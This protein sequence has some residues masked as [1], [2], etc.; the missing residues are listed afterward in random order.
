MTENSEKISK[1]I[2]LEVDL[3]EVNSRL[4]IF[5]A[6][7]VPELTRTRVQQLIKSEETVLVNGKFSKNSY[8]LKY[9]DEVCIKIPEAKPLEMEAENIP[10]DVL[11]EEENMLII[12][13]PAGM[14]THP[15]SIEREHTLVNALLFH[16]KGNLSGINGIMRPGILHRLDRDTSGLLMIAKND[17]AHQFLAEQIRTKTAVRQYLAIVNGVIEQDEGTIDA[18]ID[19]HPTQRHKMGVVED[20]KKS[21]THW[22]VLERFE[23]FTFLEATLETGRTHQIRVHFS[24]INHPVAGDPLYGGDNLK[25]KLK[26]QAL[27]AY[28][29]K[30]F[31]PDDKKQMVIEI[32]PDEDIKKL[33]KYLRS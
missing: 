20:G 22:K 8:K 19:R 9:G 3:D 11:Y 28:R 14:L 17:F 30:F 24:N 29:L 4:D 27:Q 2:N 16:C 1:I 25:I 10:L 23:K 26:G 32:E 13:K 12:N 33:L 5:V 15:T 21:I 18:P 31:K 7:L 6:N